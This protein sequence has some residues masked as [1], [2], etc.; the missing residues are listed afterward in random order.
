MVMQAGGGPASR[1]HHAEGDDGVLHLNA[2]SPP[3]AVACGPACHAR[4]GQ[5]VPNAGCCNTRRLGM[6]RQHAVQC[7]AVQE[8][9]E[10]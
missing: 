10:C 9:P 4:G 5:G 3:G 6:Y 2:A 7:Q 8:E 1:W